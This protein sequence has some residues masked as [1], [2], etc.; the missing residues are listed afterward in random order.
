MNCQILFSGTSK[1]NISMT[2]A[3]NFIQLAKRLKESLFSSCRTVEPQHQK[4]Y[5]QT[6]APSED[7]DQ[8][9]HS[10]RLIR[11]FTGRIFDSQECKVSSCLKRRLIRMRGC[12]GCLNTSFGA[13]SRR[14]FFLTLRLNSAQLHNV[15]P[16]CEKA[17]Y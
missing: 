9:A 6:Y 7:S 10:R 5:L 8:P 2:S 12:A 13:Y 1:K 15:R 3:E 4:T 17:S 11:I 14:Y 16:P